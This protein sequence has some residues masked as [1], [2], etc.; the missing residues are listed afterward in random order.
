MGVP[1][2]TAEYQ[3][4]YAGHRALWKRDNRERVNAL[5]REGRRKRAEHFKAYKRKWR[6]NR[7]E[8]AGR[9]YPVNGCCDICGRMPQGRRRLNFD[10]DHATGAFRG[11]LCHACNVLL[12]YAEDSQERL[13]A[14][15]RYLDNALMA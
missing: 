8:A 2:R 6:L 3:K 4:R 7:Q 1:S 14:A 10:H 15:V 13:L 5:A 12:G 11:W 9:P